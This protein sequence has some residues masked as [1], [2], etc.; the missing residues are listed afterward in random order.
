MDTYGHLYEES[1]DTAR[2]AIDSALGNAAAV[3]PAA[4]AGQA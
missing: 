4:S 3:A 1:E 2:D